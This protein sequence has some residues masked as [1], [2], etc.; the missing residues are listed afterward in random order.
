MSVREHTADGPLAPGTAGI[1][2]FLTPPKFK[3]IRLIN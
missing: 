2:A 3:P 1:D